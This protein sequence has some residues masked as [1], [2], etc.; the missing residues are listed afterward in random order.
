VFSRVAVLGSRDLSVS[1]RH[2]VG[3]VVTAL[4]RE[5]VRFFSSCCGQGACSFARAAFALH[6]VPSVVFRASAFPASSWSGSLSLRS[7]ACVR[8]CQ[9]AGA[10]VV[11]LASPSSFGSVKEMRLGASLGIPVYAFAC[12]FEPALLPALGAGSW[13]AVSSGP[14]CGASQWFATDRQPLLFA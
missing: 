12:G 2:Q 8:G 9:V 6:R 3:Y 11:F 5:G 4:Q 1:F 13:V 7:G 14:L 10:I